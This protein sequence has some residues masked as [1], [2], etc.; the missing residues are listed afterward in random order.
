MVA[1]QI[2][3]SSFKDF[4]RITTIVKRYSYSQRVITYL[5]CIFLPCISERLALICLKRFWE[6]NV[7]LLGQVIFSEHINVH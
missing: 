4:H 3:S 2:S 5:I 6:K 7:I 1:V